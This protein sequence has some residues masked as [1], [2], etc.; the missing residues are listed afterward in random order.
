[1]QKPEE[2]GS[3]TNP[4]PESMTVTPMTMTGRRRDIQSEENIKR[5][6]DAVEGHRNRLEISGI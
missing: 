1:M 4:C 2:T 6:R 5:V 3:T